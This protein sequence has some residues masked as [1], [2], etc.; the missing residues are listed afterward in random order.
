MAPNAKQGTFNLITGQDTYAGQNA[1]SSRTSRRLKSFIAQDDGQLHREL[2]EPAY[3]PTTLTGP[4][5]GL[6]EFDFNNGTGGIVRFYFCAARTDFTVGTKTCNFYQNVAGAWTI[7]SAVGVLA[8]APMCKSFENLFHLADGV[9]N[10]IFDGT[11]WNTTGFKLLPFLPSNT[12]TTTFPVGVNGPAVVVAQTPNPPVTIVGGVTGVL[13]NFYAPRGGDQGSFGWTF[14]LL[15]PA[16]SDTGSSVLFNPAVMGQGIDPDFPMHS[17]D[18]DTSGNITGYTLIPYVSGNPPFNMVVIFTVNIPVAGTYNVGFNHD[19]GGFFGISDGINKGFSPS[20]TGPFNDPWGHSQTAVNGYGGTGGGILAGGTNLSGDRFETFAVNFPQADEYTIEID[21]S[22][23][24]T[25]QQMVFNMALTP[26]QPAFLIPAP[27]VAVEGFNAVIGRTYWYTVADETSGR[28]TESDTSPISVS[29]GPVTQ[30]KV[31]VYPVGGHFTCATTSPTVTVATDSTIGPPPSDG[32]LV[33]LTPNSTASPLTY[34]IG[35]SLYINGTL[36]GVISGYTVTG[37]FNYLATLT[38][39]GN[40]A[41]NITSGYAVI[42]DARTTHWHLYGSESEG[43]KI[44]QF[45]ASIPITQDL[46]TTPFVDDSPF[47]D[48]VTSQFLP[49]YRPLRNDPPPPSRLLEVHKTRVWRTRF[50]TP[51]FFNY[52]ANEEVTSGNNGD[53]PECIP[54]A[55]VNTNSDLV[56]EVSFPDV[57][58]GIRAAISHQDAL[59]LFSERQCFPLYGQSYDDFALSQVTAFSMGIA[60]RF[61]GKSTPH[62]LAFVSYDRKIFIYPVQSTVWSVT[63]QANATEALNEI[64]KPLRNE[65]KNIDPTRLDEVVVEHYFFGIRDWL[66]VAYPQL[67]GAYATWVYDFPTKG[68]FQLQRGFSS[69]AVFE[70]GLGQRVLLGGA[71]DGNTYV[72]DDQNNIY[73]FVGT[74]PTSTFRPALINFGDEES[75]HIFKWL[76]LEFSNS[77]LEKDISVQFWL[78]PNDVDNPGPGQFIHLSSIKGANR[79]MAAPAGKGAV[80]QRM[81]LDITAKASTNAG[82]IRGLKLV[83][84][85]TSGLDIRAEEPNRPI[86]ITLSPTTATVAANGTQQFTATLTGTFSTQ[87]LWSCSTG[88]I[89][90]A[91]LWTAPASGSSAIVTATF[92]ED[93]SIAASAAVTITGGV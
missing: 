80:C 61:A 18:M 60:G 71:P 78:D 10:Y 45:L 5:V 77:A 56:N 13:R 93:I 47:I 12:A 36:I 11:T 31:S 39:T 67:D 69:L 81:L 41:A 33:G 89:T 73:S 85:S 4:Q 58:Q 88:S 49:I 3:L 63:P 76:E 64:G 59:Y 7:V 15:S 19:D 22:S 8:D 92:K 32:S 82:V 84:E 83:S 35:K 26:S 42:C 53:A 55:D 37:T 28:G 62:G 75:L 29:T 87:I 38:M 66:V 20:A 65:L 34:L 72:V 54:G 86:T 50:S 57:S 91:G 43:S 6:Y 44:G 14:P 1:Q 30:A 52:S 90:Q 17:A 21:Y 46:Q 25:R 70:I 9:S 24:Q 23:W 40:A 79:Y 68:W 27:T 16:A 48:D 74:C 51:N 2:V